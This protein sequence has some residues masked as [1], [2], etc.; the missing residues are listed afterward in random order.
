[1]RKQW[2]AIEHSRLHV[3]ENWPESAKR[4]ISLQAVRSAIRSLTGDDDPWSAEC[5]ICG[6][7]KH[8]GLLL[9]LPKR[10]GGVDTR[11][12]QYAAQVS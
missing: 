6:E 12:F 10:P 9:E 5:L 4:E 7:P 3:I 1:M 2:L 11:A 8:S